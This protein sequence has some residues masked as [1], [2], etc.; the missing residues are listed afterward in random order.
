MMAFCATSCKPKGS[1]KEDG[2]V[3]YNGTYTFTC[4]GS[5]LASCHSNKLEIHSTSYTKDVFP[6]DFYVDM[7]V[8]GNYKVKG[9]GTYSGS[10]STG[11]KLTIKNLY[12]QVGSSKMA[13]NGILTINKL[14]TNN[15]GVKSGSATYYFS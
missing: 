7:G 9:I 14:D 2:K 8:A 13:A 1:A 4:S 11:S 10:I 12:I 15:D 6:I 5:D 3:S